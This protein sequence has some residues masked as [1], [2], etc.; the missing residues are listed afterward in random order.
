MDGSTLGALE[1][2][3]LGIRSAG[4]KKMRWLKHKWRILSGMSA[5]LLLFGGLY[6]AY[7]WFYELGPARHTLDPE[8]VASHSEQE[9]WREVQTGI[10][11]GVWLHD[12]GFVVGLYGDKSW[13]EWIMNHVKPGTSMDCLGGYP[14]H[15]AT[16]MRFITNQDAG[17]DADPWLAWWEKNKSKS[18]E[19]WIADGFAQ[20]GIKIG[21]PPTSEQIPTTLAPLGNSDTNE[22]R[23]SSEARQ[24]QCF[25]LSSRFWLRPR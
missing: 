15:S 11:R 14:Q 18:Q 23:L 5:L 19:E 16:A 22:S 17:E 12:D 13:A 4:H 8:W 3:A 6:C 1:T 2:A 10:H 9:F 20:R 25:S 24:V 7:W 21:V